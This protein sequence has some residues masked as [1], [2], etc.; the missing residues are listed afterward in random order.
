M[1]YRDVQSK[2]AELFGLL[3]IPIVAMLA[4]EG[5]YWASRGQARPWFEN[6]A[7]SPEMKAILQ[8]DISACTKAMLARQLS[9]NIM[10]TSP[11]PLKAL[12][13]SVIVG[14]RNKIAMNCLDKAIRRCQR[15]DSGT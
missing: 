3:P 15:A 12:S 9:F 5:L 8:L 2:I 13:E 11:G 4:S 6:L 1:S 7:T 10:F 14:E